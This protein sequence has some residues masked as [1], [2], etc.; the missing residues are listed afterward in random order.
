M[1]CLTVCPNWKVTYDGLAKL[2]G[3]KDIFSSFRLSHGYR[4]TLTV[5]SFQTIH[6]VSMPTIRPAQPGKPELLFGVHH[7]G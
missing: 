6:T 5:N 1:D 2:P 4:S 3:M 7:S